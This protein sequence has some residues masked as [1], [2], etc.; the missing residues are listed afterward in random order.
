M[1]KKRV[2]LIL[3]WI[4]IQNSSRANGLQSPVLLPDSIPVLPAMADTFPV[5]TMKFEPLSLIAYVVLPG[6]ALYAGGHSYQINEKKHI[7]S[8]DVKPY[9][10]ATG[11]AVLHDLYKKQKLNRILWYSAISA[12]QVVLA[13]GFFQRL[14]FFYFLP[15]YDNHNNNYLYWAGGL[16]LGSIGAR[17]LCFRYMRKAINLYNFRYA[18]KVPKVSVQLGLSSYTPAGIGIRLKF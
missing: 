18:E 4:L 6:A 12:G 13:V 5:I 10:D 11:D 9:F 17:V 2:I 1:G 7:F 14:S 8:S 16:T 15:V 3:F